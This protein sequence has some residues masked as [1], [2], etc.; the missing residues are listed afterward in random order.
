MRDIKR[1][2]KAQETYGEKQWWMWVR[3]GQGVEVWRGREKEELRSWEE[4]RPAVLKWWLG[5]GV[6][7]VKRER[8]KVKGWIG[9][10]EGEGVNWNGGLEKKGREM[11]SDSNSGD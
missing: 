1:N 11:G 10:W 7:I 6:A 3:W 2:R 8:E 9:F 5:V 4:R